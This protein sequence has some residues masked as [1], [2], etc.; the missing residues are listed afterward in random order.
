M[1]LYEDHCGLPHS[2]VQW[3][4]RGHPTKRVNKTTSVTGTTGRMVRWFRDTELI[5]SR[6]QLHYVA[7]NPS[8]L[9]S[10]RGS[11]TNRSG[12]EPNPGDQAGLPS[13]RPAWISIW[14][15]PL[16]VQVRIFSRPTRSGTETSFKRHRQ[17]IPGGDT[18]TGIIQ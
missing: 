14:C 8:H 18:D 13:P 9:S 7:L 1:N 10:Q 5:T 16:K 6:S 3:E 15:T 17:I 11:A 2:F 4:C 12:L